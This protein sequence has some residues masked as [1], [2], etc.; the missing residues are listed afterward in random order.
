M[1]VRMRHPPAPPPPH[2]HRWH[3]DLCIPLRRN[4]QR[5]W[6]CHSRSS[7]ISIIPSSAS[8][9]SSPSPKASISHK[10]PSTS[11]LHTPPLSQI[12]LGLIYPAASLSSPF[13]SV[14]LATPPYPFSH[15]RHHHPLSESP[16]RKKQAS[17]LFFP[18]KCLLAG[19]LV[20]RCPFGG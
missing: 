7:F 16:F 18:S 2:L 4:R 13:W 20:F 8:A 15:P 3:P 10:H 5:S 17:C 1:R 6:G 9:A 12:S 19:Q 14:R 11:E